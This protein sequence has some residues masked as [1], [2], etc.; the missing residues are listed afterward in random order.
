MTES[1]EVIPYCEEWEAAYRQESAKISRSLHPV[2]TAID[3]IGSTSIPG[4]ASQPIIDILGG[5]ANVDSIDQLKESLSKVG[6]QGPCDSDTREHR[7]FCK[8][9]HLGRHLFHLY[10]YHSEA[11]DAV[12]YLAFRDYLKTHEEDA[13]L[14]GQIKIKLAKTFPSDRHSYMIAKRAAAKRIEERALQ[15]WYDQ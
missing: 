4:M 11:E 5:I 2:L 1:I 7:Y 10:V 14:Y 3:H 8:K 6:Y 12:H 15:W 9:D 13:A